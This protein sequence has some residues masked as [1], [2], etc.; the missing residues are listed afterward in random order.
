MNCKFDQK[1]IRKKFFSYSSRHQNPRSGSVPDSLFM[2][3]P[4]PY[5]DPD[6]Q[7]CLSE[8]LK[9]QRF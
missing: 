1:K 7:L 4:D 2:L 6:S 3:D 5:P 8:A 9:Q